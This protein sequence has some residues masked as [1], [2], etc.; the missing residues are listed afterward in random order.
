MVF[1]LADDRQIDSAIIIVVGTDGGHAGAVP[2]QTQVI[3]LHP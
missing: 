3:P 2:L 1:S